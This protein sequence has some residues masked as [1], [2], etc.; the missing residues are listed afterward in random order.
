M[1]AASSVCPELSGICWV[2]APGSQEEAQTEVVS[3]PLAFLVAV[4]ILYHVRC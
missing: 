4:L 1:V 3:V 2:L